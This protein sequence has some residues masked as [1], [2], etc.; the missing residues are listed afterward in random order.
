M[1]IENYIPL[2]I[3]T[4]VFAYAVPVGLVIF[5]NKIGLLQSATYLTFWGALVVAGEHMNFSIFVPGEISRHRL[6]HTTMAGFY[7]A[8][9]MVFLAIIAEQLL[10]K[11]NPT[12]W[13]SVLF[14]LIIGGGTDLLMVIFIFPH[15]IEPYSSP[16][17]IALY[18]Y[19]FSWIMALI[20]SRKEVFKSINKVEMETI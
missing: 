20:I 17:G 3:I 18:S 1:A 8:I 2:Y 11:G 4:F 5:R 15:G 16:L 10:K 14:A 19:H 6:Y 13:Y 12:G 7:T 9:G